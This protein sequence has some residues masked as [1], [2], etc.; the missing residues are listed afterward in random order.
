MVVPSALVLPDRAEQTITTRFVC[1]YDGVI[2]STIIGRNFPTLVPPYFCTIHG[3]LAGGAIILE[4][5]GGKESFAPSTNNHVICVGVGWRRGGGDN[6]SVDGMDPTDPQQLATLASLFQQTLNPAERKGAEEQLAQLQTQPRFAFLLLALVQN[7][8]T[9]TAI[10]LAAA[11][12]FKNICKMRWVS[13]DDD[14]VT[15]SPE[16]KAMIRSQLVPVQVALANAQT[17]SQAILAQV[18]ESIAL[19]ATNDFPDAW[20]ELI[21]ELVAQLGTENYHVLL[22]VLATSHAIFKR[23]RHMFRSDALYSEINL[24]LSKMAEPL[25]TLLQ[26]VH[27]MLLD[28]ATPSATMAPLATCL[29][30]LLQLFYDLSA[31]DLPPQFEDAIPVLSPMFTSLLS[32]QRP[33]LVGD[34]EDVAPSPLDKIRSSV[35]EIFE[36]YAKR[37]LDVLPQLPTFVQ[38]VWDM[39]GTYGPAEKYDVI[40]SKAIGFL[41]AVV[42]MGNQRELFAANETLEQFCTKIILPNIELRDVDEEMF[43]DN[44]MEFI[45]RDLEQGIEIDTRR[46]AATEFVRALLE[47]FALQITAIASRHI[48]AYLAA[49]A[50]DASAWR[51]KD[52]ALYLLTAV[53]AQG[54]SMQHGVSATNAHVDVV[55]FFSEHVLQDLERG[56]VPPM[57]QV[58][59]IKFLYTFR[60]QL[61]KEQLLAVLPLLVHHLGAAHYVTSTYAAITIER[62]LFSRRD[63]QRL[64]TE[65]DV[66]PHAQPILEALFAAVERHDTP[67]K[68]AENDHMM[69]CAMRVV[70]TVRGGVAPS[71]DVLVTHLVQILQLTARNVS[72]PRFTQFLFETL[73]AVVRF[74]GS[75]SAAEVH[76]M[77]ERLFPVF[78]EV[79]QADIAEY[80][81]YVFQVL[82]QLLEAHAA[83]D[84]QRVL[85][86]SYASLL[87]PLLMPALWEQKG[88]VPALV[89]LLK[90]YLAQAPGYFVEQARVEP[91]LGIYQKLISSR[92]NDVFGFDLLRALLRVL[93]AEVMAPYLQAVLTLMLV[94]LQASKTEKFSQQFCAFFGA[95]CGVQQPA[96]PEQVVASFESIQPGL[97]AQIVENV[98]VPDL[99]KLTAAQRFG[100]VAGL[101]R[102]LTESDAMLTTQ[103][104]VWPTLAAGVARLLMQTTAPDAARDDDDAELDEQGFQ[105]SF[106][107]LAAA[108]PPRDTDDN[109]AAWAGADVAAYF[110]RQLAAASA[111]RPGTLP[112]LLERMPADAAEVMRQVVAQHGVVLS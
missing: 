85:P 89:R 1:R 93:P 101:V 31:Q 71:A 99:P 17:V 79:L 32:F 54:S 84:K 112:P 76:A 97:F 63:G 92:L 91:C 39:L 77:E 88:N 7:E 69:K 49:Y 52:A 6:F 64:F 14:E 57:L 48:H 24:V 67:E 104:G 109:A 21:D 111:R 50:A 80:V 83:H 60:N 9:S 72:N 100:T 86:G 38:A 73:S 82:A 3:A 66:A 35:C 36:L 51:R 12:Q 5:G 110:A 106:T 58:A 55:Q 26:R 16:E 41:A 23:W 8:S 20:P 70:L 105:A 103:A 33:E 11:I 87:P 10:R 74:A 18:G 96:Y 47:H 65:A 29:M 61:T 98:V 2:V 28:P 4:S 34:E 13:D 37:Y 108:A 90:A 40:V 68:V 81:P 43:E 53:A 46:R 107:Q 15:V 44:P 78:T 95:F 75:G 56:D 45:R 94:R 25:L 102:L 62:V 27:A 22:A 59:A 30:L 19:V 42:R